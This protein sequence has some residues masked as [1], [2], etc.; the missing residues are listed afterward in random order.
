MNGT[1]VNGY[2]G[3]KTH[4]FGLDSVSNNIAN[5]NTIGYRENIPQFESLFANQFD[6]LNADS[7]INND[8]NY[9]A[10]K[11]SNAISTRSGNY[12]ASDGEF[13][14]A[15]EGKGWFIVGEQ[16]SG[17]FEIKDDGYEKKQKNYFTRDGSFLRDG[18]GYIVNTS[19]YY[20][21]GVDL[22]KIENDIFTSSQ[23]E[24]Q[25]TEALSSGMLKPLQ[26]PQNLYYRPVLTTRV[27][28]STNL[29]KNENA[30]SATKFFRNAN[31]EFDEER[32]MNMDINAFA[33]DETPLNASSYNEVCLT[34]D[35]DVKKKVIIWIIFVSI[36]FPI[37]WKR[38]AD[39]FRGNI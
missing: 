20:M 32:F 26:V 3:I 35:K 22:G 28:L 36:K 39:S 12:K 30:S 6:T 10:T 14:V 8:M 9:G 19:G 15:Y 7:P 37:W 2:S 29:N 11:S 21:Y 27:D 31:G 17:S 33:T 1:L 34:L 23:S 18:E 4:Q 16:K 38:C 25:D 13:N 24:E 5:V